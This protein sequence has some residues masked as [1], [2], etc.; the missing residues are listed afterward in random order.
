MSREAA[1]QNAQ[2]LAPHWE[3]E[4]QRLEQERADMKAAMKVCVYVRHIWRISYARCNI[5]A[6]Y[7]TWSFFLEYM[8]AAIM[9]CVYLTVRILSLF[10]FIINYFFAVCVSDCK[11]I[12]INSVKL[13]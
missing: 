6:V 1:R 12:I 11:D 4:K 2:L 3:A 8:K 9:L 7:A 13:P 5:Y 10:F